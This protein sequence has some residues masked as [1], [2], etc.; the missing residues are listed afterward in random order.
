MKRDSDLSF[1]AHQGILLFNSSLT[2]EKSKP[3]SHGAI[4]TPFTKYLLE[5]VLDV[6]RVPI[7]FLGNEAARYERYVAPFTWKFIVSH[8]ASAAYTSTDWDS[9]DLFIKLNK[10]LRDMNNITIEWMKS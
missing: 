9:E 10:I 6:T 1:L 5:E 2:C 8:P 4:W 7:V 3:G